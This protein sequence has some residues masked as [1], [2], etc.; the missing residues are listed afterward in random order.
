MR[1]SVEAKLPLLH[2]LCREHRVR[3]LALF[4]SAL[5]TDFDS[6]H[7]DLAFGAEFL[8]LSPSGHRRAYFGLLAALE[9]LFG[10][11]VDLVEWGAVEN[12]SIRQRIQ[13]TQETLYAAA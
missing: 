5:R 7:S 11:R 12:P 13:E 8:P 10:R 1:H 9:E 3:R 6:R 4:G 2:D